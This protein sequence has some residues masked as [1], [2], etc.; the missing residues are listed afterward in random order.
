MN[1]LRMKNRA[2]KR[3]RRR[4]DMID[5]KIMNYFVKRCQA[6]ELIG[7]IKNEEGISVV[8]KKREQE[9]LLRIEGL[10]AGREVKNFIRKIY[11]SIFS[12]SYILEKDE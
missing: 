3:Y 12:A 8:D 5:G 9:I 11:E 6:V 7:R 10:G 4:I 1:G 2:I